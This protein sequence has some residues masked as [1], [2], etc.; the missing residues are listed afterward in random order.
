MRIFR[1]LK[2]QNWFGAW[3]FVQAVSAYE[4]GEH[5]SALQRCERAI[6]VDELRTPGH[7]LFYSL[8]LTLN[9]RPPSEAADVL[10][11]IA[12]GQFKSRTR[13]SKYAEALAHYYLAYLTNRGDLVDRWIEAAA[14]KPKKGF[15]AQYLPLPEDP[16]IEIVNLR[17]AKSLLATQGQFA[18]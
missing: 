8:L 10:E 18:D 4:R 3:T 9:K 15:A 7:M 5:L 17:R 2:P 12:V 16:F 11:S 14:R 6:R 1:F 13:S